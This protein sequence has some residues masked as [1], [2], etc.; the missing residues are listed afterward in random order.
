MK[1]NRNARPNT[2]HSIHII[3]MKYNLLIIVS[4][5]LILAVV[6]F[7]AFD[8]HRTS[9]EKVLSEFRDYQLA[10]AQRIAGEIEQYVSARSQG[11]RVLS[12]FTSLLRHDKKQIA[13]D[14]HDYFEQLRR[15]HIREITVLDERGELLYSTSPGLKQGAGWTETRRVPVFEWAKDEK[16][17]GKIFVTAE[18][19]K[20]LDPSMESDTAERLPFRL[21]LAIPLYQ[22]VVDPK[23]PRPR[24]KFSGAL[25]ITFDLGQ[26]LAQRLTD[27]RITD[28]KDKVWVMDHDGTL[29]FHSRVHPPVPRRS[30]YQRNGA[31]GQCHTSFTYAEEMLTR[32]QG[33]TEYLL[34]GTPKELA[35]FVQAQVENVSWTVVVTASKDEVTA[36]ITKS[37][38]TTLTLIG[39]VIVA[40]LGASVLTFRNYRLRVWS[41]EEARQWRE[42]KAL[43]E[44]IQESEERYRTFIKLSS[45]G[46]Y[47][48][49]HEQPIPITASEDEQINMLFDV[50]YLA[51]CNDT[52]AR[53]YGFSRAQDAVG[54]RLGD[55]FA[56]SDS[57]NTEF[58]RAF[59]HNGYRLTEAESHEF[60]PH[61][62][63]RY[64]S[65]NLVGV[66]QDG[67][68]VRSWGTQR[69]VTE[70]KQ[71]EEAILHEAALNASLVEVAKAINSTMNLN[72][73][74]DLIVEKVLEL[75]NSKHG[76]LFLYNEADETLSLRAWR[77]VSEKTA[78]L[79][80]FKKGES[81]A[82]WVAETGK[83]VLLHDVQNHPRFKDIP[84][85][86]RLWSMI[87]VPLIG[88]G[89]VIGV[90]GI[91]RLKGEEPFTE[92]EFRIAE[93]FA[94][95][96]ALAIEN[97]ALFEETKKREEALHQ[98][99]SHLQTIHK[100]AETVGRAE[101]L[102]VIYEE[103]LAALQR[104][105][106]ADRA[107]ILLF[108]PDGVIR[109]KASHGL[110][111]AYKQAVEGHSPWA[112]TERNPKPIVIS[113]VVETKELE[114]LQEVMFAEGIRALAFIPI[115]H[116]E[117]LLGKFMLYFNAPRSLSE[118]ELHVAQTIA[119]DVAFAIKRRTDEDSLGGSLS[120]L[121]ATLE[122]TADGILVVDREGKIVSFNRKFVEMWQIPDRIIKTRD[123]NQALAFVRDQLKDPSGFLTKVR[124]LYSQP[125]A[126]SFDVL[127][128]IDGRVFERYSKPQYVE[129]TS[130]GRVWSFRDVTARV[131]AER[132]QNVAYQIS[133]A[134]TSTKDLQDL[135]TSI[136]QILGKVIPVN[137]FYIAL[138]DAGT[139]TISFPYFVDERDE[140]PTPRRKRMGLTEYVLRKGTPLFA[141]E[142]LI[143]ELIQNKEIELIGTLAVEW[144]G[145]PLKTAGKTIGVLVVQ[146]YT[147]GVSLGEQAKNMLVFVSEQVAMVI[148]RKRAEEA[149]RKNEAM[150]AKA[151]QIAH[152]GN[153]DWNIGTNELI[154]SDEI[155]RIFGLSSHEFGASYEAFLKSVHPDDR[156]MVMKAVDEALYE[157]KPY[158]IDHRIVR[159]NGIER[160]VHE[161][162]VVTFDPDGRPVRMVG[163]VQ[164]ITERKQAEE[165]IRQS[166]ERYRRLVETAPDVIY[167]LSGEDGIITSLNPAFEKIL[168]WSLAE[169]VGKPFHALVH[170]DDIPLAVQTYEQALRGE[171]P[172]A[173]ELRILSKSGEYLVGEFTSVPH[174]EGGRIIGEFG[175][176]RD[177]TSRK[178]AEKELSTLRKAVDSSGEVIFLTDREGVITFINPEFTRLYGHTAE[179]VIGKVTPRIL[180]SGKMPQEAYEKLWKSILNKQIVKYEIINKTKDGKFVTVE[181]Y[182]SP[183]LDEAGN[184]IGFLAIQRDITDRKQAEGAL[185]EGEERMRTLIEAS[186]DAIFLKDGEGRWLLINQAAAELYGLQ[187]KEYRGK[188][189]LELGETVP[190]YRYAL[191]YSRA[192]DEHAWQKASLSRSEEIIP[193]ENGAPRVMDVVKVPLF[194]EDGTRKALVVI[195]RDITERKR[196]EEELRA[197]E[198]RYRRLFNHVDDAILVSDSTGRYI[199]V[200]EGA[201]RLTGYSQEEL[202]ELTVGDIVVGDREDLLQGYLEFHQQMRQR[203][204]FRASDR[205]MRRKD[206]SLFWYDVSAV[207]VPDDDTVLALV[208][209]ITERRQAEQMLRASEE[210]YRSLFEES[211]DVIYISTPEG[212]FIDINPAGVELF[213]YSSREELL[214]A[215]IGRDLYYSPSDREKALRVL[216]QRGFVKDFELTL[217]RKDGKKL[218]VLETATVVRDDNGNIVAYRGFLRDVTQQ[219]QLE[220]QFFQAQ[221]LESLG[222]LAGGV[223]HDFNN[224]LA[225]ILGHVST[226][227]GAS[228]SPEKLPRSIGAIEKAVERGAGLVRQLL[229]FAGKTDVLFEPVSVNESVQEL[230]KMVR[231]TFPKT[232][233]L[234]LHL[235]P[236]LPAIEAD[237]NQLYQVL[238]NLCV[239]ARDAMPRGGT[240]SVKTEMMPG[241]ALQ[242]QIPDAQ[243][244]PYVC[245]TVADTGIG[246]EKEVLSRIFDPFFTTKEKGKGT[247]LGLAVVDGVVKAHRGYISAESQIGKGTTFKLYFPVP[248]AV[249]EG[250]QHR[251]R[252]EVE[253][254]SGGTEQIL[255][256][257]DEEMLRDLVKTL[258]EGKG[259]RVLTASDGEQA[260][261]IYRMHHKNIA[262]LL[263]DMGLPKLGGW[264]AYEKMKTINPN[265]KAIFASGYVE[266]N[267]R[268]EMM[269][270]GAKEFIQKPYVLNEILKRI[271]QVIDEGKVKG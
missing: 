224:I 146:S 201:C 215:D 241:S 143:R 79:V 262:L 84:Q 20:E 198:E 253:T 258:L 173:Y 185:R 269:K 37:L 9:Q 100:L 152:L 216:E 112:R 77:G 237:R 221:R 111:E 33:T 233:E 116:Q 192:S 48:F 175:I 193:Q 82:G 260:V 12:S 166:E 16:N 45:E 125:D 195:G 102:E 247:G 264:E 113:N 211:K 132:A 236:H 115:V 117:H 119:H 225:I 15:V 259:Y 50:G 148:E 68:L 131:W 66:V 176:A 55:F 228:L 196:A 231:E 61:G 158:S 80:R 213:G 154:W 14:V 71:K 128:F 156:A 27:L 136:H 129:G 11:I 104:T 106:G 122:S 97:S 30:I 10:H 177:I 81:I 189:D 256:V 133:T 200:N 207:Y 58:L 118:Q 163:T 248:P 60:N 246:M 199:A 214:Q 230:V 62:T 110:S 83:G 250:S 70:R 203:R 29:L 52:F 93:S 141:T 7:L 219:R 226:L 114:H 63:S 242:N 40:L 165:L 162:A 234:A 87:A 257:E 182:A 121:Q 78:A 268:E 120:L 222:T 220:A 135:F 36:F 229:T 56:R 139:E 123:D 191:A 101:S 67:M 151:Q 239:N 35:A 171:S 174:L 208:R 142:D 6:V 209:D 41:E 149:L 3:G 227:K 155:Y 266:P 5:A 212:K 159:P 65:N 202:L 205:Q 144:F 73:L 72:Q 89:K 150:L 2:L 210:K 124:E 105:L 39:V 46:I 261:E 188:T 240:L 140:T 232:I 43:E 103:A 130:V 91:D 255:V 267:L 270:A 92:S 168:G 254:T 137:N 238:L 8:L 164:D 54:K 245:I 223:A 21:L 19:D 271:R 197:R 172:P 90:L 218:T 251:V 252:E 170:P 42:K 17:R 26:W 34:K 76:G 145:V 206:G 74:L 217:K 161:E 22:D 167:T 109:F 38:R 147:E 169:W 107:S 25:S 157:R 108:D 1:R 31:C 75:T 64:F 243:E 186:S 28:K 18:T 126:E 181:E 53:M 59:I 187:G 94:E 69:E 263:C 179:E 160:T 51:E 127:E 265:L 44:K 184:I 96:A 138:Y 57:R 88:R 183:V 190:F 47:R 134:A 49:E 244:R 95:Q 24:G 85:I 194:A 178:R 204:T 153:W 86:E 23:H 249:G 99:V 235:D 32:K 13:V 180:K 4:T 98:Q